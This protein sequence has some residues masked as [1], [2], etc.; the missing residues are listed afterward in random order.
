MSDDSRPDRDDDGP[1]DD[2]RSDDGGDRDPFDSFDEYRDRGG[3]PFESL[4]GDAGAGEAD[5][6]APDDGRTADVD[7]DAEGDGRDPFEYGTD[8]G[9]DGSDSD[10]VDAGRNDSG[11]D[12][13]PDP[14]R[15]DAGDPLAGVEVSEGDPFE[16]AASAFE[17]AGVED[18]DPDDVWDRLTGESGGDESGDPGAGPDSAPGTDAGPAADAGLEPGEA[19][20]TGDEDDVVDVSKHAYCEGCEHFSPPP[21]VTCSHEGTEILAFVD[22]DSVR[23]ANCPVVAERRDLEDHE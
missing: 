9:R 15:A 23:V 10:R 13:S 4:G 8:R 22:V 18:I 6:T 12:H 17:R 11:V 16:S 2:E 21:D 1:A 20:P 7:A 19:A 3:D 5:E 14:T